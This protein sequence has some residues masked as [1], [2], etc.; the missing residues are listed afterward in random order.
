[1]TKEETVTCRLGSV[2][3]CG[4]VI[5]IEQAVK[6]SRIAAAVRDGS[7]RTDS[8]VAVSAAP[9]EPV[10]DHIGCIYPEMGL[11]TKTALAR[12]ART[13]ELST[14]YDDELATVRESLATMDIE[15][16]DTRAERQ[17]RA[18]ATE[19]TER[20]RE[21]VATARGRLEARRENELE[22]TPAAH[23]LERAIRE[24]TETETSAVAAAEQLERSREQ[25][26][27]RRDRR[28]QKLRLEDRIANLQRQARAHLVDQMREKYDAA[29]SAVPSASPSEDP[30]AADPVTA[31]LAV[32]RVA[33]LS[34]PVVVAC[35]RFESA[36]AASEWL[37]APVIFK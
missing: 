30:F 21:Q 33:R 14:P 28:E 11:R 26:R 15:S 35:E 20:L 36:T 7:D 6:L 25:A 37:D 16:G 18:Q 8:F 1:M 17:E 9:P 10:H 3:R 22:S 24:L 12:A 4:Q 5:R 34:A 31:A 27:K 19:E 32:A 29:V 2:V 13:R 23:E